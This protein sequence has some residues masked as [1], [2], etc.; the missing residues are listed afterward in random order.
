MWLRGQEA[1]PEETRLCRGTR[2]SAPR[3]INS[4]QDVERAL[5]GD[6]KLSDVDLATT[7]RKAVAN[8]VDCPMSLLKIAARRV[9]MLE[10]AVSISS[11]ASEEPFHVSEHGEIQ[12]A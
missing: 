11:C 5:R 10:L 12:K 8:G 6:Q 4:P 2:A 1:S 7:L 9:E 3:G